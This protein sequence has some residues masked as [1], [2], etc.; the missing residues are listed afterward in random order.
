[1][2]IL[3]FIFLTYVH[4]VFNLRNEIFKSK[5]RFV[6]ISFFIYNGFVPEQFI[7]LW[8]S[9]D[10]FSW[11]IFIYLYEFLSIQTL[12]VVDSTTLKTIDINI[13]LHVKY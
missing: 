12:C 1:M 4:Q 5:Y 3:G 11:Q 10:I 9:F 6:K 2:F 7:L 13:D 8:D